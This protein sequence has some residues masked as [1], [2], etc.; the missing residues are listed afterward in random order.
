MRARASADTRPRR[1]CSMGPT[2]R[3]KSTAA[4]MDATAL[5]VSVPPGDKAIGYWR[6]SPTRSRAR[7]NFKPS[8]ISRPSASMAIMAAPGSMRQRPPRRSRSGAASGSRPSRPGQRS[9]P[10]RENRSRSCGSQG[11]TGRDK[12]RSCRS[13]AAPQS[14][15]TSPDRCSTAFMSP[16]SR[17]RSMRRSRGAQMACSMSPTTSRRR[18][19]RRSRWPQN[20]SASRRRRKFHSRT[21]PGACRR[22]RYRFMARASACSNAKLRGELGVRLRYP[23]YREGLRA[24]SASGEGAQKRDE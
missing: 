12:T 19:A 24:L 14:A 4:L 9:A 17:R 10:V 8:S 5:L 6:I 3:R 20:C 2:Q 1:S 7:R 22:W 23:T 18:R 15:S 21:P 16:T 13:R 11:F